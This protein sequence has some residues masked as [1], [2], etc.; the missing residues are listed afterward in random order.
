M[1]EIRTLSTKQIKALKE[2]ISE[3]EIKGGMLTGHWN[4]EVLKRHD[5]VVRHAKAALQLVQDQQKLL[6]RIRDLS[7]S[8]NAV[9]AN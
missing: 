3:L 7:A 5:E 2:A 9:E 4:Q 1:S 8:C 6:R